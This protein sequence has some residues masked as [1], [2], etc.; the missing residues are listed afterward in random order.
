MKNDN[1]ITNG[2][3][4]HFSSE[5]NS[6]P[7]R[8]VIKN[9]II[10][11]G[12]KN[13]ALNNESLIR[14]QK[15]FSHEIA[16]GKITSQN[17]SGRCWLF[18]GMNKLRQ[19][20]SDDFKMK[21]FELSQVQPFF[22]DKLEKANYFLDNIIDTIEEET[23]SRIV[24]YL[25]DAPMND[26]GQWEMFSNLVV[27]Y[28]LMPKYV[29]PETF[30]SSD[31]VIMNQL[32]TVKLRES[33]SVLRKLHRDGEGRSN[34]KALKT[35]MLSEIYKMLTFFMGEPPT[36]FNFEYRDTDGEFHRVTDLT[37][38]TFRDRYLKV[39]IEDYVSLINAPTTDKPFNRTF[40]VQYLGNVRGGKDVRY[41]NLENAI[42]KKIALA[43][44]TNGE[45]V[46]F[47]CD[48]GK[49]LDRDKGV[50]DPNLFL[51]DEALDVKFGLDKAARLDYGETRMTHAMLFTG[52]NIVNGKPDRWK[53]ENSW[54]EKAGNEG[55]LIMS[56]KWFDEYNF[57]VVVNKKYLPQ[58]LKS[59]YELDPIVLKPW[60]PMGSLALMR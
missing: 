42:L 30:H 34:L 37:P 55:F 49:M 5:F 23:S 32:L 59:A 12:I 3:L 10:K 48:V 51:Y 52:V 54:G 9:A 17:K 11:N 2:M 56:D 38:H 58:E 36:H 50:I 13:V 22:Y 20:I 6:D 25:L 27:K 35:D 21:D 45:P 40:T 4:Q 15:T 44:L 14:N 41:L 8:I 16:T 1:I 29:M 28:G 18:A 7:T 47:G 26:G 24:M 53:V 46:W 19:K 39:N 43:Q 31:A 33:A 60:D 57:Q